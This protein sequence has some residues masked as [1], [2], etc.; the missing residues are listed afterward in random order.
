MPD[1]NN[2]INN[3]SKYGGGAGISVANMVDSSQLGVGIQPKNLDGATPL[4]FT[5][6]VI[7]VMQL[8][9]MYDKDAELGRMIKSTLESS[10]KSVT[11]IDFGYTLDTQEQPV[12]HDGQMMQIPGK[13]KRSAVTPTFVIPEVTGNL[14]WNM[15]N[16]WTNDAQDAD[17]NASMQRI[18]D[19]GPFTM[20]SYA[21]SMMAIQYDPTMI[22]KNIV[23]AAYYTN[24]FPTDPGGQI[25]LE[26]QISTTKVMD[27]TVVFSGIVMHN[28]FIHKM[29]I[30][31]AEVLRIRQA[32]YANEKTGIESINSAILES[33]LY[34]EAKA[35][36]ANSDK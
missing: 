20:S 24:M 10:S 23:A 36:I 29:G 16:Q 33:G 15:Y 28:K 30:D 27:R 3:A 18:T 21:M 8:P 25:G 6:T 22:P 32:K 17:T 12:G 13:T 34:K 11:G 4:L 5:P 19:P 9:T 35:V 1:N 2:I 14:I 26:R 7:V 31:I